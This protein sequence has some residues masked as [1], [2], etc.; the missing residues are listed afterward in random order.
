M[1]NDINLMPKKQ[2]GKSAAPKVF[3][4][5][6]V[7]VILGALLYVGI[8]IPEM[9]KAN[10]K[11]AVVIYDAEF[12]QSDE[13]SNEITQKSTY[14]EELL[15][16]IENFTQLDNKRRDILDILSIIEQSCP[17][18]A[19][20]SSL[21][22]YQTGIRLVGIAASDVDIGSFAVK[23]RQSNRFSKVAI[24]NT[25]VINSNQSFDIE[26]EFEDSLEFTGVSESATE[27]GE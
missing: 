11:E 22:L 21:N 15:T 24:V 9:I 25:G 19:F 7:L 27:E 5:V 14:K 10:I 2:H 3:A 16:N 8:R 6:C 18:N 17:K 1:I 20:I 13:I 4:A 12:Q 23:L 26:V